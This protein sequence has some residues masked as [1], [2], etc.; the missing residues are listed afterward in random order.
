MRNN[1]LVIFIGCA[2]LLLLICF[3]PKLII[4]VYGKNIPE[5]WSSYL[6]NMSFKE[7]HEKIGLPQEDVSSKDYQSWLIYEWWG[8]RKLVIGMPYCCPPSSKPTSIFYTVHV[9]GRYN[10]A[11]IKKIEP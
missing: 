3:Y 6:Y 10:P 8:W 1:K 11:Y 5:E 2:V 4:F 9:Y 7:I